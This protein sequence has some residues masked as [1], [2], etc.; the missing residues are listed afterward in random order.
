MSKAKMTDKQNPL[1]KEF[2]IGEKVLLEFEIIKAE[3]YS[4]GRFYTLRKLIPSYCEF[5]TPIMR[6]SVIRAMDAKERS[7]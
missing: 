2:K 3:E 1:D 6:A 5:I 4:Y 7:K